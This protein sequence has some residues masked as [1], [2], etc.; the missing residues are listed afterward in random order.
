MDANNKKNKK[1]VSLRK[2]IPNEPFLIN[3]SIFK[4]KISDKEFNLSSF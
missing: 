1:K 3:F 4:K 2:F